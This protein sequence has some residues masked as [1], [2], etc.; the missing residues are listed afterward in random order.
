MR[1]LDA[2]ME[3]AALFAMPYTKN[4]DPTELQG[5]AVAPSGWAVRYF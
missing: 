5:A 4:P 3:D 2:R 1:D